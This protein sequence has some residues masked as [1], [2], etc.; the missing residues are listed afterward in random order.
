MVLFLS[1]D[2][3]LLEFKEKDSS[4]SDKESLSKQDLTKSNEDD[5]DGE[6]LSSWVTLGKVEWKEVEE[7]NPFDLPKEK[8]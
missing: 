7:E 4:S 1:S 3:S 2:V 8:F 6:V 5:R